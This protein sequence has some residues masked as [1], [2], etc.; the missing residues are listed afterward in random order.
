MRDCLVRRERVRYRENGTLH[1]LQRLFHGRRER[2]ADENRRRPLFERIRRKIRTVE[3]L[4]AQ[5]NEEITRFNFARVG[6]DMRNSGSARKFPTVQ[7]RARRH[8]H[9]VPCHRHIKAP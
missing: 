4:P 8:T 5:G 1:L 3:V 7:L 6:R 2:R 9:L